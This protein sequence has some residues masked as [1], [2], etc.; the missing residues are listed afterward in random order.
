MKPL[1]Q[2]I[3]IASIAAGLSA[4]TGISSSVSQV[5]RAAE[6]AQKAGL[7][8]AQ[9]RTDTFTL[10]S[11]SRLNNPQQTEVT[12]YLE[13]DGFA[14]I[15]KTQPS[16][17]PTP[18][19]PVVIDLVV[20]DDGPNAVYL[21]RPCQFQTSAPGDN[22]STRDWTSHRY[23]QA[24]VDATDQA[25]DTILQGIP[26]ARIHLVGYSG[27]GAVAMLIAAKR[28]ETGRNNIA[29][30]RTLAGNLDPTALMAAAGV[31]PLTGS[32]D[33]MTIAASIADI[34]QIHY[35]GKEDKV[36]PRWVAQSYA[37]ASANPR[38]I[39]V[40]VIDELTHAR[41]WQGFWETAQGTL[42]ECRVN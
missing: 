24:I 11:L 42:P 23:S 32:L 3:A 28:Q 37:T 2:V 18:R 14:W 10:F 7:K 20:M 15:S 16:R 8:M 40:K 41:R 13:G 19:N 29:S 39:Q 36:I 22:C 31:S 30:I 25:I 6:R 1:W 9:I 35:S 21:A 33:P 38:C 27:G 4:C 34:P 12:L 26:G 5:S 17:D